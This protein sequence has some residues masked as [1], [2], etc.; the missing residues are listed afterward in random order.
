MRLLSMQALITLPVG[1]DIILFAET[2]KLNFCYRLLVVEF[3]MA[4]PLGL[5]SLS[6]KYLN[7]YFS[8]HFK[9]LQ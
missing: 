9:Y 3:K 4:V 1:I 8:R 6:C 2:L 5:L 7:M